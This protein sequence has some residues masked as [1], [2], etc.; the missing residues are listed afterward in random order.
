MAT[1]PKI[2]GIVRELLARHP[3]AGR[4]DLNDIAEVIGARAVTYEEVDGIITRLEAEG[5][6]VGDSLTEAEVAVMHRVV[7]AAR[8]LREQLHRRPTI[9]EIA[10]DSEQPAH[11][12]RRALEHAGRAARAAGDTKPRPQRG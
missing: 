12:V 6:S 3:S 4:V 2:E 7:A 10:A 8:R 9:E 5:L 1:H 11:A